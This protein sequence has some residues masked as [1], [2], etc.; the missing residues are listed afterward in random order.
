MSRSYE[1]RK[2]KRDADWKDRNVIVH[3]SPDLEVRWDK[4][5]DRIIIHDTIGHEIIVVSRETIL[6]IAQTLDTMGL[7]AL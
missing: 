2:P 4:P 5:T 7:S 3:R 1:L 6:E